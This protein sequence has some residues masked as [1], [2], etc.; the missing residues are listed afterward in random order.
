MAYTKTI[1][2]L[3][4]SWK[5][6]G[7]CVAGLEW[8]PASEANWIRP[9]SD[10]EHEQLEWP[11][12]TV[13]GGKA[14]AVLDLIEV[15]LLDHRPHS[16]QRENH[17]NDSSKRWRHLGRV[18]AVE[19]VPFARTTSPLWI[20]GRDTGEGL[21]DKIPEQQAD[22][23]DSSLML[24]RADSVVVRVIAKATERGEKTQ[25]RL[26]FPLASTTYDLS[27]TDPVAHQELASLG[28]GEHALD[29]SL[30]LC[31]SLSEPSYGY[32]YK[33]AAGV[34]HL[35]KRYQAGDEHRS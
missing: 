13:R 14:A 9:V 26:R 21:N 5:K 30:A 25:V 8:P 34:V 16:C 24:V 29:H 11:E 23:L 22:G 31:V 19:L 18:S 35:P 3:A 7:N 2:C 17:L 4:N 33:L 1:V 10:R 6:G 20:D 32:R 15:D 12:Y 27:V 28:R